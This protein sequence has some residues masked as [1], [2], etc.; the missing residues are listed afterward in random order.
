MGK[1]KVG[2]K[3][4]ALSFEKNNDFTHGFNSFREQAEN[5]AFLLNLY[6]YLYIERINSV[7]FSEKIRYNIF[8]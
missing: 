6:I 2:D 4:K 5:S 8:N 3:E 7:D 1:E